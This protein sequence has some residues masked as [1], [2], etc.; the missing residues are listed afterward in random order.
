MKRKKAALYDPYLDVLGGGE[1]HILSILQILS[2]THDLSIFWDENIS[3]KIKLSLNID[4]PRE[5]KFLP[6]IFRK[7]SFLNKL[8]RLHDFDIF[9]Y[10]TDGSYFFSTAKNNYVFC[11]VP[12]KKLYK[13]TTVNRLKT[14]NVRFISNS[15]Y[16]K[17]LLGN[18]SIVS[19]VIYPYIDKDFINID[20][21]KLEKE[22][23]I[24]SVGRFFSHLHS[25]RQDEAIKAFLELSSRNQLLKNYKLILAGGLKDEDK[26]YFNKLQEL[27]KDST[28]II[29]KPN[30]SYI[31]LQSLYKKA[32][33]YWHFAGFG[34]DENLHPEAVE[35]LG[36][37]PLEAMASGAV[38]FCYN[39][40]G[41]KEIITDGHNGFLFNNHIDLEEKMNKVLESEK[42]KRT[43]ADYAKKYV[44]EHFSYETFK[45][46][47]NRVL[48]G[49]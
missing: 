38:T 29:L 10:V 28:S 7:S 31:E 32:S 18:W 16:T 36:I 8:N 41:P 43:L 13:M 48:K 39:A 22:N 15:L 24:L 12:D 27:V 42:L 33:I 6:N 14:M 46:N 1:K 4:L 3:A 9:F 45:R 40:G 30:L 5:T 2:D 21:N 17:K 49:L 20:I 34:V 37:T 26:S 44:S 25:K 11:M 23:I 35:H 19:Q 47:V